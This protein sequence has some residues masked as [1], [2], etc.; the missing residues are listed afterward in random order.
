MYRVYLRQAA[1]YSKL[2]REISGQDQLLCPA[3]GAELML[4]LQPDQTRRGTWYK[5]TVHCPA[6]GEEGA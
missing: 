5:A 1:D 2:A 6:C 4:E 3:C